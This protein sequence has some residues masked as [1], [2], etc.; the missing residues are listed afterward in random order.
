M[1]FTFARVG[2]AWRLYNSRSALQSANLSLSFLRV[3][4]TTHLTR[5]LDSNIFPMRPS[6][7]IVAVARVR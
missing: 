2:P 6:L 3:G 4:L 1:A 7:S 5:R